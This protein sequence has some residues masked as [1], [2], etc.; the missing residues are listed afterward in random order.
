VHSDVSVFGKLATGDRSRLL[1]A[2]SEVLKRC[3]G[4]RGTVIMPTFTYDFCKGKAFDADQSPSAVGVLTEHFRRER[5]VIR[6]AHPIFSVAIWGSKRASLARAGMDA[7]GQGSIFERFHQAKGKF[8]FLGAP[9]HSL[10]FLHYVEQ[11]YGVPYRY[12]KTFSG[13]S[14]RA[15]RATKVRAAY[16]VRDL[17]AGIE[18]DTR[19]LEKRLRAKGCLR[20]VSVGAGMIRM[21]SAT[22]IFDEGMRMLAKDINAFT[23]RSV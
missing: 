20:E 2:F 7:F 6:T 18:T 22:D 23:T 8:V 13:D 1:S 3:V 5:G 10:T 15:G 19:R 9:V 12:I 14:R 11:S 4:K 17:A 21:A 16:Y